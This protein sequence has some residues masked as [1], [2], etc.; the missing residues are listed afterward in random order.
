MPLV[1][2]ATAVAEDLKSFVSWAREA[3]LRV[4]RKL[5]LREEG[6]ASGERDGWATVWCDL[7][8]R[9]LRRLR[10]SLVGDP[11]LGVYV[12]RNGAIEGH[13]AIHA[14][15]ESLEVNI[16]GLWDVSVGGNG[17]P[18]A[19]WAGRLGR[20]IARR[21]CI[22]FPV[23]AFAAAMDRSKQPAGDHARFTRDAPGPVAR[24]VH[25]AIPNRAAD[26]DA[27]TAC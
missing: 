25:D 9:P 7:A 10:G 16:I 2:L 4:D 26:H 5:L 18:M 19:R 17:C 23:A 21:K 13:V 24:P 1:R 27:A 3:G 11:V 20:S 6:R 22:R 14:I 12:E 15:A 8:G